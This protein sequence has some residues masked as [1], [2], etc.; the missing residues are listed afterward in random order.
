MLKHGGNLSEA[1][2]EYGIPLSAWIDLSTGINPQHYPISTIDSDTWQRLPDSHDGL[3]EAACAYYDCQNVLPVA[4]S[5]AALQILPRL[6]PHC[7]VAM[8]RNMYQEHA[9]AWQQNGHHVT[10]LDQAP[11]T[12]LLHQIDVLLLCNPNNPT[13]ESYKAEQLLEWLQI[14]DIHQGWLIVDEAFMDTTPETSIAQHTHMNGLVVLRSLG[15]FFGLAGARVGFLL[16]AEGLLL[17][18][19]GILGPWSIAGPSRIIAK[20]ALEDYVWHEKTRRQL[21]MT[22]KRLQ[23]TLSQY[24]LMSTGGTALFQYVTTPDA[25]R[26]HGALAKQGVWVRLFEQPQALRFGLPPDNCWDTFLQALHQATISSA[27]GSQN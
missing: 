13:G 10:L 16:A 19:Q 17:Q 27:S 20:A 11:T 8:P 24:G 3:V 22:S 7:H 18:A 5:Q 12:A 15:K 21:H 23:Q 26:I 9:H 1:A 2:K 14:L 4:G 25:K 6:K